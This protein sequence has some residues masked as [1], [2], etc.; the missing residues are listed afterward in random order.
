MTNAVPKA[1]RKRRLRRLS[2]PALFQ[3]T[4]AVLVALVL[5]AVLVVQTMLER[6]AA[7]GNH[8][9]DEIM[10]AHVAASHLQSALL[11]QETGIRGYALTGD[12]RFLEPY[13]LGQNTE[14]K[15]ISDLRRLL[16]DEPEL[17]TDLDAVEAA[18]VRW[19]EEYAEPV[20]TRISE[21]GGRAQDPFAAKGK[22]TFDV[23]RT[24]W[25]V[26]GQN[27]EKARAEAR[28]DLSAA[29]TVRDAM[30][31][32]VLLVFLLVAVCLAALLHVAVIRPLR[33][34]RTASRDVAD[35]DFSRPIPSRGPADIQ[36]VG[37][38]VEAMRERIVKELLAANDREKLLVQQAADLD[39]QAMELRR[40]NAELEQFAY[41]ASHDLQE[42]LR[43]VASFCQMLERRYH[44]QLDDRGRQYIEFAT[45][46]AKRMQVLISDLLT[47]SRVGRMNSHRRVLTVDETLDRALANLAGAI[48][49][50]EAEVARPDGLPELTGDPTLLSMLWQNLVGNALKFRDPDAAP[51]V[52]IECAEQGPGLWRFT[53]TDNG[54]GIPAEY[55]EKVFV[56]FQRLHTRD[57]YEGTGIGLAL[58]KKIVEY[59]GGSIWLDTEFTGGS[60]VCFT[61]ADSPEP[62]AVV[63]VPDAAR[64]E[65][66]VKETAP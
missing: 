35:G 20:V 15:A 7:V 46:G 25:G 30:L 1:A 58:C 3:I 61:L 28:D 9:L 4:L 66:T 37:E 44:D 45:D 43:K 59:H 17:L 52:R 56:I 47:F 64:P 42:P 31:L 33:V 19:R 40:S 29:R 13:E 8:L 50:A 39:S 63:L 38:A 18:A 16:R 34:L 51:R 23:L 32:A 5:A 49:E 2:A 54:I 10:P 21:S 6:T 27:L 12:Q 48:S 26:Q 62:A 14:H 57:A 60:R 41:V 65:E 53:V 24:A 36:E 11:D 22:E 55:A